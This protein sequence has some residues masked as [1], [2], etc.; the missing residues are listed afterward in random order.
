MTDP[1]FV[2]CFGLRYLLTSAAYKVLVTCKE[3][4]ELSVNNQPQ[5]PNGWSRKMPETGS[6]KKQWLILKEFLELP[7]H[8]VFDYR[9]NQQER[10][11]MEHAI[12]RAV[13][14]LKTETIRKGSP[15][16]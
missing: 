15:H 13:I 9:V 11:E 6:D 1:I 12:S 7:H 14:D 8:Q 3:F 10:G 5:P 4:V 2:P 16:T